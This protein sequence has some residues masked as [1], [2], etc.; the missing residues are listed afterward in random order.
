MV[1]D[2]I[3]RQFSENVLILRRRAGLSQEELGFRAELHRTEIG[4]LERG[5]RLPRMDTI[6]K[7]AGALSI[8]PGDLFKGMTWKPSRTPRGRFVTSAPK[9][10]YH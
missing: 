3:A 2:P 6:V 8:P 4:Q 1:G 9:Q 7:L 5:H 10:E